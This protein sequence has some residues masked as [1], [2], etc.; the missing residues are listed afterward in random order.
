[1]NAMYTDWQEFVK[2][3]RLLLD[4]H[5]ATRRALHQNLW[6]R[7]GLVSTSTMRFLRYGRANEW[8]WIRLSSQ[9]RKS[10]RSPCAL[11]PHQHAGECFLT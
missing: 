11:S 2:E 8:C 7:T 10:A 1:L 3:F 6:V 4:I 5:L 9:G